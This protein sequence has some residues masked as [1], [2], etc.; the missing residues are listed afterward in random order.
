MKSSKGSAEK[1][2]K[3]RDD[4]RISIKILESENESLNRGMIDLRAQY[5]QELKARTME[6]LKLHDQNLSVQIEMNQQERA[7]EEDIRVREES[8]H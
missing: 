8:H 1:F 7:L 2:A 3:E 4:Y 5:E 6:T